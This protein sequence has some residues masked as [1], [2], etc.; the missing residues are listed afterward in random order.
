MEQ[1]PTTAEIAMADY[2]RQYCGG[3]AY[4]PFQDLNRYKKAF[5]KVIAY[6]KDNK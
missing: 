4:I 3:F 5:N 6:N 2:Y 1:K